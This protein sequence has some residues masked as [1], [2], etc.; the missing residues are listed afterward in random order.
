MTCLKFVFVFNKTDVAKKISVVKYGL[1]YFLWYTSVG[2]GGKR[3]FGQPR[4]AF[5]LKYFLGELCEQV[6]DWFLVGVLYLYVEIQLYL[7]VYR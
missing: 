2:T 5:I 1:Q 6:C 4:L 7:W 3:F